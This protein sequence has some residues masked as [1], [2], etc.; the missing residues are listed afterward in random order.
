MRQYMP[1]QH[2]AFL[3]ELEGQPSLSG[4]C[5]KD[6]ALR[7]AL[8]ESVAEIQDAQGRSPVAYLETLGTQFDMGWSPLFGIRTER[9]K[10]IRA[11]RPELYDLGRDP[12]ET[13]NVVDD[14]VA[15]A[16]KLRHTTAITPFPPRAWV[17]GRGST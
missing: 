9:H 17:Q 12:G 16:A 5:R 14:R 1:P 3:R 15:T 13:S 7:D 8:A 10:Y 4:Y 11:P 6:P 2:A